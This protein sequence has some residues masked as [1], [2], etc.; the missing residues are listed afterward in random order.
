MN[1]TKPWFL[2][3][4][5]D[6]SDS[7]CVVIPHTIC[8]TVD[9]I[10]KIASLLNFPSYY[11]NN[12]NAFEECINDLDWIKNITVVLI[13]HELPSIPMDQQIIY[14][15]ILKNAV[16]SWEAEKSHDL[17]VVLPEKQ[18]PLGSEPPFT[19]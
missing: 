13:H 11:G 12:W 8:S 4:I 1:S 15:D 3:S 18:P 2:T 6:V 16:K 9:F 5:P 7:Y 10:I 17:I 19:V 14:F